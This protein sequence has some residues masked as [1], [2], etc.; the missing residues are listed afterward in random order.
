M[1]L[2]S[3]L[4]FAILAFID[5]S[6]AAVPSDT[7]PTYSLTI[8]PLSLDIET[9]NTAIFSY[10][11]TP[12]L[13]TLNPV[14]LVVSV[15]SADGSLNLVTCLF[16]CHLH[17][18][19]TQVLDRSALLGQSNWTWKTVNVQAGQ[20]TLLISSANP[21]QYVING[22]SNPFV[23]RLGSTSCLGTA[24]Q[25]SNTQTSSLPPT[26][27]ASLPPPRPSQTPSLIPKPSSPALSHTSS[28]SDTTP[29]PTNIS[30]GSH[31]SAGLKAG[32]SVAVIAVVL[33][34]AGA[35]Y[36][37]LMNRRRRARR[38]PKL[39]GGFGPGYDG[40]GSRDDYVDA[41]G[42]NDPL[43]RS[44]SGGL[45][46]GGAIN[47]YSRSELLEE[48][49]AQSAS[50][51]GGHSS[52]GA[53]VGHSAVDSIVGLGYIPPAVPL[54]AVTSPSVG[55]SISN[56]TTNEVSGTFENGEEESSTAVSVATSQPARR[57]NRKPVPAYIDGQ[58]KRNSS[59][60]K[61]RNS[62]NSLNQPSYAS[63]L[64]DLPIQ[65]D[66]PA[67]GEP[68][69]LHHKSSFGEGKPMNHVLMPDMPLSQN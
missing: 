28:S 21:A 50:A 20:Y 5:H 8:A 29:L 63:S 16:S 46:A 22:R 40:L 48:K 6:F 56:S 23:V 25:T 27:S 11:V 43:G 53:T 39:V 32:V 67:P 64:N 12:A 44:F 37:M 59:D 51:L 9:C 41:K 7:P 18:I 24:S 60:K 3:L 17:L 19:S 58:K 68:D 14:P 35:L 38:S 61:Q 42:S 62:S 36:W 47:S 57:A 2:L 13:N 1:A 69:T 26:S 31:T 52:N 45:P 34:G 66:H 30:S 49:S 65:P 54:Q 15:Q 55:R 4:A 33:A 10:T